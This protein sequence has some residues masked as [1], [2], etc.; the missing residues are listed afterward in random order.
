MTAIDFVLQ[1]GIT[2][3]QFAVI[4]PIIRIFVGIIGGRHP[5]H[6]IKC[7]DPKGWI[8]FLQ[9]SEV[10]QRLFTFLT[11]AVMNP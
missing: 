11:A 9:L 5:G 2:P 1:V 6:K 8:L 3:D 4:L 10:V 7:M